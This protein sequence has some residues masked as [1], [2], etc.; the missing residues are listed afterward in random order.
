M[1]LAQILQ[2]KAAEVQ[3]RKS[4]TPLAQLELKLKEAPATRCF[5]ESLTGEQIQVIAE[6]KKASPAKGLLC[7][8]FQPVQLAQAYEASGA[9]AISV[10]TDEKFFLGSLDDLAQ[11]KRATRKLPVLRK[12]FIIDRYQ[13]YEARVY[14][15]DAV[16]LIGAILNGSE[17]AGYIKEAKALGMDALVEVHNEAELATAL[18]AGAEIIGINN[19]DLKTFRV[20]LETTLRLREAIPKD[21]V[22]VAESGIKSSADLKR[23]AHAGVNAVL[24]GEALVTAADPGT[25]LKKLRGGNNDSG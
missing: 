15:A 17:L 24:V 8:D 12:D 21:K 19:R 7:P 1:F 2:S 18:A 9:A 4:R 10:L 11:V 23:L 25:A 20:D 13:I 22:V 6:I 16:L 5:R 3:A 14:G